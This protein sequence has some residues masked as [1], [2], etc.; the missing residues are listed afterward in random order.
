MV[1]VVKDHSGE[2]YSRKVF[3]D[4]IRESRDFAI[5]VVKKLIRV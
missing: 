4:V 2:L 1:E 3:L 5:D